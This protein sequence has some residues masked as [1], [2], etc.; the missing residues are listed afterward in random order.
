M[1]KF[2]IAGGNRALQTKKLYFV[3]LIFSLLFLYSLLSHWQE[4]MEG[5]SRQLCRCLL[6][7]KGQCTTASDPVRDVRIL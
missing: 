5:G 3:R 2:I 6:A 4:G 1:K 7:C